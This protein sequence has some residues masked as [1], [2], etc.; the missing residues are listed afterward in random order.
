M[1][2]THDTKGSTLAS[3][4]KE[5]AFA[6]ARSL[7]GKRFFTREEFARRCTEMGLPI[8]VAT[9]EKAAVVGNGGHPPFVRWGRKVR[10]PEGAGDEWIASRLRLMTSTS[11]S[12]A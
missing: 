8:T 6:T 4:A 11:G 3:D 12:A 7:I 1:T 2:R 10:I 5:D 9:L